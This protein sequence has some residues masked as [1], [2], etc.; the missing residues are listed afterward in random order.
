[1]R[2]KATACR[3]GAAIGCLIILVGGCDG[4][5]DDSHSGDSTADT[6]PPDV[7]CPDDLPQFTASPDGGIEAD[8]V[9]HHS[10]RVRLI[11]A[12]ENPPRK[13][14]DNTWT[15]QLMDR[16]GAPLDDVEIAAACTRMPPPHTHG[17]PPLGKDGGPGVIPLV[18]PG[19]FQLS[20]L[21]FIM[22]GVWQVQLVTNRTGAGSDA[23]DT[24]ASVEPA[25]Q[26]FTYC[27]KMHRHPGSELSVFHVCVLRK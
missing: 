7:K 1:M 27:D 13:G 22:D 9:T 14:V 24:D 15:I 5:D 8:E 21:N 10:L 18:K 26:E 6:G 2:S 3:A 11:S 25:T 16:E 20:F 17:T 23:G 19:Q 4:G 12:N